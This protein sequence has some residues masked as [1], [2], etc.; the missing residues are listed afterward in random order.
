MNEIIE[1]LRDKF[2]KWKEAFESKCLTVK[3]RKIKVIVISGITKDG[4][5][6]SKVNP[7]MVCSLRVKANSVLCVQCG[8]CIH[9]RCVG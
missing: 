5:S 3:L 9:G 1:G 2:F 6:S 7:Y 4:S 8:R